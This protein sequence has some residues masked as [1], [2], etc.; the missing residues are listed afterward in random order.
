MYLHGVAAGVLRDEIRSATVK[1]LLVIVLTV[2]VGTVAFS[3]LEGVPIDQSFYVIVLLMTLIGA[4]YT[5]H[6]L[7]GI[8]L[9]TALAVVSVGIILSFFTQVLAPLSLEF[10]WT[11][12]KARRLSRMENHIV[13]CGYSNTAKVLLDRVPKNEL[14]FVVKDP[15]LAKELADQGVAII[16]GDYETA[17]ILRK[18]GVPRSRAV[19]A[20]SSDDA[21]NAFVCLTAKKLAPG[22]PVIATVSSEENKEKLNEVGADTIISPALLSASA[23]V[24]ALR[25]ARPSGG[26]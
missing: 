15:A 5:P 20:L 18:A 6:S 8:L 9:S 26:T 11:G 13:V 25:L 4:N 19:I 23:I 12:L 24:D 7:G 14:L 16:E 3:S 21:D 1:H 17:E 2:A 10:Y 22:V